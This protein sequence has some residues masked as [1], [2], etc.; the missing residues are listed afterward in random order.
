MILRLCL[1]LS[2]T[3]LLVGCNSFGVGSPDQGRLLATAGVSQVE[4]AGGAGLSN[5]ATITGYGTDLSWGGNAHYTQVNLDDFQLRSGGVAVGLGNRMELSYARQ[6]FDLGDT[7]PKL[8]LR[9][10]YTFSQDIVGAKVRLTGDAVYDQDTLMPQISIGAQYKKNKNSDLISALGAQSDE[11][12]DFY[13]TGTKLFLDKSLL[14]SG[15]AR[16]TKANQLGLLGFGGDKS[17]DYQVEFE[18]SAV[19]LI[20]KKLA[21]GVDYRTK[22]NNLSFAEEG[23]AK[24]AY[25]AYFINKNMSVTGAYVDMGDIALQ[26][27]QKG[28]YGSLQLGF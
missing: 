25:L 5:W 7:G 17:N 3:S 23:D 13:I 20:N 27:R 1:L 10:G 14:L 11:G 18:G 9:D 24:A 2:T 4:G 21:A 22:P 16:A 12:V 26:G 6:D 19:Y 8:G 28:V 15:S